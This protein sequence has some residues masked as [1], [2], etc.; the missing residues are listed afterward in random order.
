MLFYYIYG[1]TAHLHIRTVTLLQ[2][3][4]RVS[5]SLITIVHIFHFF[6]TRTGLYE[7]MINSSELQK[8]NVIQRDFLFVGFSLF[9]SLIMLNQ[10][11]PTEQ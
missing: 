9:I 8:L 4:S 7:P 6:I 5:P 1:E 11:T 10:H 2:S 3:A